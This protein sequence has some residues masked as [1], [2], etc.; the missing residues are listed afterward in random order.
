MPIEYIRFAAQQHGI[1]MYTVYLGRSLNY[2][3][4]SLYDR[5]ISSDLFFG[6]DYIQYLGIYIEFRQIDLSFFLSSRSIYKSPFFFFFFFFVLSFFF[7][8]FLHSLLELYSTSTYLTPINRGGRGR[9]YISIFIYITGEEAPGL[10]WLYV[11]IFRIYSIQYICTLIRIRN[12]KKKK[13]KKNLH[14]LSSL[15]NEGGSRY[16]IL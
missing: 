14:W 12:K 3:K 2:V 7:S 4:L 6:G 15:C 10:M 16:I 5:Y 13:K 1:S 11:Y 8:F 9:K